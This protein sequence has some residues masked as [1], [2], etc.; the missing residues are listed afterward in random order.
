MCICAEELE[1]IGHSIV[2]DSPC[3]DFAR[4]RV[5]QHPDSDARLTFRRTHRSSLILGPPSA[6]FRRHH[7]PSMRLLE[8]HI[9]L[10]CNHISNLP[11]A[12]NKEDPSPFPSLI[13]LVE[14]DT[15]VIFASV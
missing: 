6:N 10:A 5:K 3:R 4:S 7:C 1:L 9:S 12:E 13:S 11:C 14:L 8:A 15:F 2:T